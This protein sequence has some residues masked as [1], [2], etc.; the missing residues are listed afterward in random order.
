MNHY[1]S[2]PANILGNLLEVLE[3][4]ATPQQILDAL[5]ATSITPIGCLHQLHTDIA[6]ISRIGSSNGSYVDPEH[7]LVMTEYLSELASLFTMMEDKRA[8]WQRMAQ[9]AEEA[10]P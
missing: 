10:N 9:G 5:N 1:D 7:L 2:F 4:T 8:H 6:I 3:D